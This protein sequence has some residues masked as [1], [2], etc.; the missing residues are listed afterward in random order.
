[1]GTIAGRLLL[2]YVLVI[3][4]G[5]AAAGVAISGLLVRYQDEIVRV[6]LQEISAPM[7]A[8]IQQASRQ[9]RQT[10]EIV[11][12]LT[13]QA[14]AAD[15]RLLIVGA[16]PQRRVVVDSE[17]T[18]EGQTLPAP[19]V[20]G[21]TAT[22]QAGG[23]DWI[24]VQRPVGQ[25]GTV[26]IA[27]PKAVFADTARALLPALL[28]AALVAVGFA[29]VV[30]GL[31]ARGITRPLRGLVEDVRRFAAGRRRTRAATAGPR[32]VRELATAFNDMADEIERARGSEQ[33]FLADISHEL[34]T[35]L[36]SIGGFAQAI[37]DREVEGE[38]TVW[39]A[40]VIRRET[41][42][43]VRMVEGLLQVARLESGAH[44]MA[45]APVDVAAVLADA[46]EALEV[47]AREKHVAI[48]RELPPLP[49]VS[50]DA[51]RLAQL[52]TNVLDNAVKHSPEG[53]V[54]RISGAAEDAGVLVRVRDQ[55]SG[56]QGGAEQRLFQRFWRGD[57]AR[58]G[59]GLGLAIAQAIAQAHG[60]RIEARNT[61][62]GGAE[63]AVFLPVA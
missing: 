30:A 60:G 42:R 27:R 53:S 5:T 6:R 44:T 59:A 19:P 37:A 14:R 54:V 49:R 28:V 3:A 16:G 2:S 33:A 31:L 20:E 21:A 38:Q 13:E 55:G 1:M 22:F 46:T 23:V 8:A 52:F 45:R 9:G 36:T 39:A 15:L 17:S 62:G 51:D 18:L 11:Q 4:V 24:F 63:F 7:I 12:S 56:V 25:L 29:L 32:E 34:R 47:Q 61:S 48:E 35:P 50:G 41:K 58:D 40:G 43:L 57:T 10:R 26:V